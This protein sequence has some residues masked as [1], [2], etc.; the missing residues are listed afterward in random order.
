MKK[1]KYRTKSVITIENDTITQEP[2]FKKSRIGCK[3]D[4][5]YMKGSE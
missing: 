5:C 2:I 3:Q 1:V 4:Y